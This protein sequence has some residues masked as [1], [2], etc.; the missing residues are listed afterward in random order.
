MAAA[1]LVGGEFALRIV[2]RAAALSGDLFYELSQSLSSQ[3]AHIRAPVQQ[4]TGNKFG[5]PPQ[6]LPDACLT[7]P[8]LGPLSNESSHQFLGLTQRQL[9]MHFLLLNQLL[10]RFST[11]ARKAIEDVPTSW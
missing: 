10:Q 11:Q 7:R 5:R 4:V 3:L 9:R 8:G 2:G 1:N 6:P